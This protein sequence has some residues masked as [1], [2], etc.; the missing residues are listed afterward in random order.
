MMKWGIFVSV[1]LSV[2]V[3]VLVGF[4]TIFTKYSAT[5]LWRD[6]LVSC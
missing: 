5:Q 2:S 4:V 1:L 6:I 3:S